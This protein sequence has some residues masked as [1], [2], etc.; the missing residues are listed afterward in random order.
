MI[1][2][3]D[4]HVYRQLVHGATVAVVVPVDTVIVGEWSP[5]AE[6]WAVRKWG[7]VR[8]GM[9]VSNG[10]TMVLIQATQGTPS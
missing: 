10:R 4:P 9:Q 7:L 6:P 1:V 2:I 5:I 3:T 8:A